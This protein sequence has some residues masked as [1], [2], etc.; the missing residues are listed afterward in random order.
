MSSTNIDLIKSLYAAFGRGDIE[1]I[2][3][4]LAADVDWAVMGRREDYPLFGTWKGQSDVRRFFHGVQEQ[5]TLDFSPREF[6]AADDRVFVLG[7]YTWKMQKTGRTVASDW[8]HIFTVTNG[9]VSKFR[10]FTDT[11]QFAAAYRG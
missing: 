4:G 5:Q 3:A 8:V 9:K 10:E 1:T 11:A 7:H 2:I 6:Y